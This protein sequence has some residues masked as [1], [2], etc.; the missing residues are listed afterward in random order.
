VE[1]VFLA[2][3]VVVLVVLVL[4]ALVLV[5]RRWR[6]VQARAADLP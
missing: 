4:V 1:L 6:G 3:V 5:C 2:A